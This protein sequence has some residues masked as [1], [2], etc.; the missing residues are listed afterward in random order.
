MYRVLDDAEDRT[1]GQK[2]ECFES[3][4]ESNGNMMHSSDRIIVVR[5]SRKM[6]WTCLAA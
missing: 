2:R 5:V 3:E 1:T 6:W 4:V